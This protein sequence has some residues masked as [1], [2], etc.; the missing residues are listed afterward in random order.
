MRIF[1]TRAFA[2][3]ARREGIEDASLESA[4][5][6]AERGQIDADLG[7]G[8]IKQRVPRPGAGRSAGFRT[9]IA[10][11]TG[12]ISVF[13]YGFAKNERENISGAQLTDLRK[14]ARFYFSL[15]RGDLETAVGAGA[16][17]EIGDA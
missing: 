5:D 15:S 7:G 1:K 2:R 10:Y 17:M 12:E 3:F 4:I 8:I 16:L 11:R 14:A 6:R 9:V 13:L